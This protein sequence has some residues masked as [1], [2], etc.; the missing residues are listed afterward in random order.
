MRLG[1][2]AAAALRTLN[3]KELSVRFASPV[4]NARGHPSTSTFKEFVQSTSLACGKGADRLSIG[5]HG[6]DWAR[7]PGV[8]DAFLRSLVPECYDIIAESSVGNSNGTVSSA[9]GQSGPSSGS[10]A[11]RRMLCAICVPDSSAWRWARAF[12]MLSS[13]VWCQSVMTSS[14]SAPSVIPMVLFHQRKAKVARVQGRMR[15]GACYVP[16]VSQT[17]PLDGGGRPSRMQASLIRR[18]LLIR[19]RPRWLPEPREGSRRGFSPSH[20]HG[21]GAGLVVCLCVAHVA[22]ERRMASHGVLQMACFAWRAC[23]GAPVRT[24]LERLRASHGP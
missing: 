16:N 21:Q 20:R 10:S 12:R 5:K 7:G 14:Q 19:Q 4:C 13:E 17:H 3:A 15:R 1:T 11:A 22:C 8:T 24:D 23:G 9:E 2:C 6:H 18:F